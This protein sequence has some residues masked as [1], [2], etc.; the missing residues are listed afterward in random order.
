MSLLDRQRTQLTE[1]LGP[2]VAGLGYELDSLSLARVGRRTLARITVD[3]DDGV[4]LDAIARIS[5]AIGDELDRDDPFDTPFVLEVS[6]PGVDRP[7]TERRHWRRNVGRL[8]ETD[9]RGDPTTGRVL[10]VA[11]DTVHLEVDGARREVPLSD[12]GPG[13]VQV[14]FGR[15]RS[16]TDDERSA[17]DHF[18]VDREEG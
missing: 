2:V 9:V 15:P 12:L 5:R 4:D 1:Q 13:R 18:P 7:L 10:A 17:E 3:H 14:E 6:S 11:E 16:A 8:V